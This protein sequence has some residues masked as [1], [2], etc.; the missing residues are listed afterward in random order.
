[1]PTCSKDLERCLGFVNYHRTFIK[2]F[3]EMAYPL[4]GL[5]GKNRF[6]WGAIQQEAFE[7]LKMLTEPP[8]LAL[9]NGTDPFILDTDASDMAIVGELIQV[10]EGVEKV[11]AYSSSSLTPEQKNYCTTRKELLSIVRF[12]RQFKYY[13]L[14]M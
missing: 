3:A 6:Q 8:I 5:T 1:M 11:N 7:R 9:P 12:T 13:L 2:D 10:Q 4:Y 14:G